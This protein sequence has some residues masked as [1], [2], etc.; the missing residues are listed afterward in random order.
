MV[1]GALEERKRAE[2]KLNKG[3]KNM[4]GM[5]SSRMGKQEQR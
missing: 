2:E 5:T 3:A 1:S 4:V